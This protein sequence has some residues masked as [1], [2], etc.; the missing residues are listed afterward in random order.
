MSNRLFQQAIKSAAPSTPAAAEGSNDKE[1]SPRPKTE[2]QIYVPR[3]RREINESRLKEEEELM[4]RMGEERTAARRERDEKVEERR[5]SQEVQEQ[6]RQ[7]F[8][9][10]DSSLETG[11]RFSNYRRDERGESLRGDYS[12]LSNTSSSRSRSPIPDFRDTIDDSRLIACCLVIS[13]FPSD[14]ADR[15]KES[16]I[17][18][19]IELGALWKWLGP[20]DCV[21]IFMNETTARRALSFKTKSNRYEPIPFS[22]SIYN[23]G[24]NLACK[25]EM[26][27]ICINFING[28]LSSAIRELHAT[29]KPERD[30][31]VA[32]RLIGAALGVRMPRKPKPS[33]SEAVNQLDNI[34]DAWDD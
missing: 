7:A 25:F 2:R 22:E 21:L 5:I 34:P 12:P 16:E 19:F 1:L 30:S 33:E 13:G 26:H 8:F 31:R 15:A 20:R 6:R 28:F 14:M 10:D 3:G 24:Q 9:G 29:L 23:D 27:F 11:S 17:S 18:K 4:K 32:N